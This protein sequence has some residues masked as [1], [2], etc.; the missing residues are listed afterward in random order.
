MVWFKV[1]DGFYDHRKVKAIPRTLRAATIGLWALAGNYAA[2][3]LTDGY[4]HA[5]IVE[6]MASATKH[7][8]ELV[9]V[10][11]WHPPGYECDH[12]ICGLIV[13][14]G[15]YLFHDYL[16][17]NPSRIKVLAERAATAERQR[18][19]RAK[20]RGDETRD[21]ERDKKRDETSDR[22]SDYA[23]DFRSNN[24]RKSHR[25]TSSVTPTPTRPDKYLTTSVDIPSERNATHATSATPDGNPNEECQAC[26]G[27]G[28]AED[29]D[30]WPSVKC[31]HGK[32][33]A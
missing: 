28:W 16:A 13:P 23:S 6:D 25:S 2:H 1:D 26:H 33:T 32:V 15:Q 19:S 22:N 30:G 17:Y 7:A 20:S 24:G 31:D 27:S 29:D 10:G 3:Q 5:D 4:V 14:D 8:A 18:R 9:R 12:E 11:L 21:S